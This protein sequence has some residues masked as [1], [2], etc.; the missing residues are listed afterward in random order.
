M[1]KKIMLLGLLYI[2]SNLL[3]AQAFTLD[4]DAKLVNVNNS[5][6]SSN[7]LYDRVF[8]ASGLH[9]LLP[10]IPLPIQPLQMR[11]LNY[12]GHSYRVT[13]II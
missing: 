8:P 6:V 11:Y 7:V 5:F 4:V 10:L 1:I 3:N 9:I 13:R 12:T 2:L